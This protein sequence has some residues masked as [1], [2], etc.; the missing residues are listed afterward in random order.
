MLK[1]TE[2]AIAAGDAEQAQELYR[3]A[4]GLLDR[5]AGKGVVNKAKVNRQ[6]SRLAIKLNK[7]A[8][9]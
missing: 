4:A 3:K 9:A 6:K 8:A 7:L 2:A 5:A 1:R